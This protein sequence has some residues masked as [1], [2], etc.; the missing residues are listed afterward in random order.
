MKLLKLKE[1]KEII[2]SLETILFIP[3]QATDK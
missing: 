2:T 1:S 3:N